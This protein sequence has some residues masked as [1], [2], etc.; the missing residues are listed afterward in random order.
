LGGANQDGKKETDSSERVVNRKR[1]TNIGKDPGTED[2]AFYIGLKEYAQHKI[3][4]PPVR[5]LA[6]LLQF[7]IING[8]PDM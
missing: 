6:K 8:E 3:I 5:K 1:G 4:N 2:P 7:L